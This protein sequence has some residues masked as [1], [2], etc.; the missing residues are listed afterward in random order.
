MNF[1]IYF[2]TRFVYNAFEGIE[3]FYIMAQL[4]DMIT[5]YRKRDGLS[6]RELAKKIGV[7]PS[8][9]GM[10][11]SGKRFPTHEIE[12]ALADVFNVSLNNLR[13]YDDES[14][15]SI[16]SF[17]RDLIEKYRNADAS[18]KDVIVRLLSF[19]VEQEKKND[20]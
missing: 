15:F 1:I 17:E 7:S 6:Q 3:R 13:G 4:K 9:I 8:T 11:E 14:S 16:S 12:E 5:Y 20:N 2:Y 18:T 10:Y 19:A